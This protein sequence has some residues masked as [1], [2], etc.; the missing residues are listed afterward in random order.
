MGVTPAVS[1]DAFFHEMVTN[2]LTEKGVDATPPTEVY[3]V[4]LLGDF[5]KSRIPD[6]PLSLMLAEAGQ[7]PGSGEQVRALKEVGD[8]TLYVSGFFAESLHRQLVATD[9]YIGLGEAAYGALARRLA[10][11]QVGAVYKELSTKFPSFVAVLSNVRAKVAVETD[12]VSLYQQ[13]L[14][15]GSECLEKRLRSFGLIVSQGGTG[16]GGKGYLQ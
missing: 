2:A 13:W 6:E 8:T 9:Y 14:H 4:G 10:A 1:V 15:T 11:S 16:T 12:V 3:L 5:T 7:K